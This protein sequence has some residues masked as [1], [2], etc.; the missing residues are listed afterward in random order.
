M[1]LIESLRYLLEV[2]EVDTV[3][4]PDQ[5][6]YPEILRGLRLSIS[7]EFEAIKLYEQLSEVCANVK[8]KQILDS[9]TKEEKLHVGEFLKAIEILDPEER[10]LYG[11]GEDETKK[12]LKEN[13]TEELDKLKRLKMYRQGLKQMYQ[14]PV[15]LQCQECKH[16]FKVKNPRV[17]ITRCPK[18]KS[19]DL[20]M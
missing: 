13:L 9:V 12:Y 18:C 3:N 5:M 1:K 4:S 7:S 19:T 17:G 8:V 11:E 10:K 20:D 14:F 16:N 15:N 6:L 2:A